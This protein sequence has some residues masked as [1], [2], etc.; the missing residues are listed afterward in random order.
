MGQILA[1]LV[2]ILLLPKLPAQNAELDFAGMG[3]RFLRERVGSEAADALPAE[4]LYTQHCVQLRLGMAEL[5]W[6]RWRL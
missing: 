5:A 6:P 2:M 1:W 4:A 3:A